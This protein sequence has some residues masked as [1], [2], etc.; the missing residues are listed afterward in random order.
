MK[1]IWGLAS[2]CSHTHGMSARSVAKGEISA[3]TRLKTRNTNK[4]NSSRITAQKNNN[5]EMNIKVNRNQ[6]TTLMMETTKTK[7]LQESVLAAVHRNK[8]FSQK[9]LHWQFEN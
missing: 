7:L 5:K 8:S 3:I 6:R 1:K 9:S 4:H 2:T